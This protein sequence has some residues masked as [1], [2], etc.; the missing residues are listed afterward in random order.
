[1]W[2]AEQEEQEEQEEEEEEEEVEEVRADS[3]SHICFLLQCTHHHYYCTVEL[4]VNFGFTRMEA[5]LSGSYRADQAKLQ[6]Q[7]K[8][9]RSLPQ[10]PSAML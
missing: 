3:S 7:T 6:T 4:W 1:M 10:C 9:S 2:K 5:L 8:H